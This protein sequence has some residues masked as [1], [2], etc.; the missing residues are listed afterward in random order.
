VT[1][2][3]VRLSPPVQ[4]VHVGLATPVTPVSQRVAVSHSF[5]VPPG[6]PVVTMTK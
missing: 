2:T 6:P 5:D 3:E 1:A 4:L